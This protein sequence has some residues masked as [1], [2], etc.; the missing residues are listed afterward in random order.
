[1]FLSKMNAY[2]DIYCMYMCT[3]IQYKIKNKF[4]FSYQYIKKVQKIIIYSFKNVND[5][6]FHMWKNRD[7]S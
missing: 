1:M 3:H 5:K 6:I 7:L 4:F 2:I